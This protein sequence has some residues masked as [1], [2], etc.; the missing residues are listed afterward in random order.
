[1]KRSGTSIIFINSRREV[2]LLLRDDKPEIPY[3]NMWDLPGGH[4]EQ[5][6]TPEACIVR[7]MLE[8]I[9]T[10]VSDCRLHAVYDFPDRIEHIFLMSFDVKADSIT[11]HEG[12]RLRWFAE[13]ELQNLPLAYGFDLV[14]NDFYASPDNH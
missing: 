10:D 5:D 3:P 13:H 4:V 7:E 14:L 8:E 2:L 12:Q 6:E 9:E 1:M 11:L